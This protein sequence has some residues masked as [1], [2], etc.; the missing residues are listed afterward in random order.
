MAEYLSPG[1]YVEEYDSGIRAVEGVSTQT[2]GFV[3]MA[4]AGPVS[5]RPVRI[6]NFAEYQ[7]TFGS[8][9]PD[10][11]YGK[12]RFLP[13]SVEQFFSNGGSACYVVRVAPEDALSARSRVAAPVQAVAGN[14][15]EWGNHVELIFTHCNRAKTQILA[16]KDGPEGKRYELK[17]VENFI[18]GDYVALQ[19]GERTVYNRVKD[20]DGRWVSFEEPFEEEPVDAGNVPGKQLYSCGVT[21]VINGVTGSENYENC[22]LN[23]QSPAYLPAVLE[24]SGLVSLTLELSGKS[25][26]ALELLGAKAGE[27]KFRVTLAGGSDGSISNVTAET[28]IGIDNG[29]GERTG[30]AAFKDI[31]DVNIIAVP[32]V[33][34][35]EVQEKLIAQCEELANRFAVLDMPL[36][37]TGVEELIRFKSRY[38]SSSA[39][40]Y[41]PWIKVFDPGIKGNIFSPPSG[42]VAGI[43]ARTDSERGVFKAPANEVVRGCVGLSSNY[44]KAQQDMLY[45][46][47][48]NPII[49]QLGRGIR[50]W[51][52]RTL[53]GS[54]EWKYVNVRRLIIFLEESIRANTSWAVFE[55]NDARLWSRVE[56]SVRIFLTTQWRNGALMGTTPDEAFFI[57]IGPSTMTQDDILNGHLVF[58][59][60]VAPVR[61]ADFIMLRIE[62][63]MNDAEE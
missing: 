38:D 6:T 40:V 36:E 30:I 41:H 55:P 35:P 43:Y 18:E 21:L 11:R 27:E 13:N 58:V 10:S 57:N 15:G 1:V 9:L 3:G 2:A 7:L 26:N 42:A 12:Y 46:N 31:S 48:I 39:A 37:L 19:D 50:V 5:G 63:T 16:S 34:I 49:N 33:T 53:S 22:S 29:V 23:S 14:P 54:G 47:G 45:P 8:Y 61:P 4:Q 25:G 59:V 51:G 62:H 32:G 20:I 44:D 52:A 28:F 24:K 60:G 56:G 17:S